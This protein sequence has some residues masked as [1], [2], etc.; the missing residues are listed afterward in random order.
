MLPPRMIVATQRTLV[1]LESVQWPLAGGRDKQEYKDPL[2][3][4]IEKVEWVVRRPGK[5]ISIP[6][7]LGSVGI[8]LVDGST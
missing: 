4:K 2:T 1:D 7:I 5:I 8:F 6:G 3:V